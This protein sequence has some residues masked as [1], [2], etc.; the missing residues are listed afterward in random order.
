M[1]M[2]WTTESWKAHLLTLRA[3]TE[4]DGIQRRAECSIL[5]CEAGPEAYMIQPP[6][7]ACAWCGGKMWELRKRLNP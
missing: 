3:H 5:G 2:K 1:P 4:P 7:P 6:L